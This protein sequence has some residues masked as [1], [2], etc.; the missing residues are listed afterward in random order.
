MPFDPSKIQIRI[1]AVTNGVTG[2]G[3]MLDVTD[4]WSACSIS[5]DLDGVAARCTI[6]LRV[7]ENVRPKIPSMFPLGNGLVIVEA[8]IDSATIRMFLG[9]VFRRDGEDSGADA[10]VEITAFDPLI[11]LQKSEDDF[12][13]YRRTGGQI[14]T[15]LADKWRIIRGEI[16]GPNI[17]LSRKVY[18]GKSLGQIILDC[19]AETR[20]LAPALSQEWWYARYENG[21]TV[22]KCG[23]NAEAV[24]I[25]KAELVGVDRN[26]DDVVT[27]VKI[28]AQTDTDDPDEL[29][30]YAF[31]LLTIPSDV[32]AS[33]P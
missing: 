14:I 12:V 29:P 20:L 5:E 4:L 30:A 16:L 13:A 3:K 19:L 24:I 25:E 15:A 21:I 17:K 31:P 23:S 2:G 18:R 6:E 7:T 9:I 32:Q 33:H 1:L 22:R 11:Y 27:Q 28:Y 8:I 26:I 10:T